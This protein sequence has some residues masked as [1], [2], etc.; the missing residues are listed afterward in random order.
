MAAKKKSRLYGCRVEK[1]EARRGCGSGA[2]VVDLEK[3]V[4]AL[5]AEE[6]RKHRAGKKLDRRPVSGRK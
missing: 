1:G 6:K 3:R 2:K 4:R 5:E